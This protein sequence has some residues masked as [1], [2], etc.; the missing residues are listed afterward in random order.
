MLKI[1]EELNLVRF[2]LL[3]VGKERRILTHFAKYDR[4]SRSPGW[5]QCQLLPHGCIAL[6]PTFY[7]LRC[8]GLATAP[9]S[10]RRS[11]YLLNVMAAHR[12]PP[13]TEV[14]MRSNPIM[15]P[16]L[17]LFSSMGLFRWRYIRLTNNDPHHRRVV[18]A[19]ALLVGSR[20]DSR[21]S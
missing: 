5:L 4:C 19:W 18:L 17:H 9:S 1:A 20:M 12:I 14:E 13:Q 15:A 8:K 2:S 7:Q 16:L 21:T 3:I 11:L 6:C 10:V